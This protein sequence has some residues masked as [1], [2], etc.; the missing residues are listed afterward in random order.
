MNRL[1]HT[2][3]LLPLRTVGNSHQQQ[4]SQKITLI[5]ANLIQTET[6]VEKR[7]KEANR[8]PANA[9]RPENLGVP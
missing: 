3:L 9:L 7:R 5:E 6:E 2:L 1:S 8:C 4:N